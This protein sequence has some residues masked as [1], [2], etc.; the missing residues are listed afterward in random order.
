[1]A[2]F[3]IAQLNLM[4]AGAKKLGFTDDVE[5]WTAKRDELTRKAQ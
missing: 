5:H 4:I 3:T 1:M 2:D